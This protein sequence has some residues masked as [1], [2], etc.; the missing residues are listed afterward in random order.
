MAEASRVGV[1][2]DSRAS[3][4]AVPP[5]LPAGHTDSLWHADFTVAD[6]R[7]QLEGKCS[8]LG[9]PLAKLNDCGKQM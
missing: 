3:L 7:V 5:I 1:F 2:A 4:G 8:I 9:F 6:A